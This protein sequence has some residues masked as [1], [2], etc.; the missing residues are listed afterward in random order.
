MI[1]RCIDTTVPLIG[2]TLLSPATSLLTWSAVLLPLRKNPVSLRN[3]TTQGMALTRQDPLLDQLFR[4]RPVLQMPLELCSQ[5]CL[6][7]V[8]LLSREGIIGRALEDI[9]L[10]QLCSV[11]AMGEERVERSGSGA[12]RVQV[13]RC[14]DTG[15]G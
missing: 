5:L 4:L 3:A 2:L 8:G 9:F 14:V 6:H 11:R 7:Q 1:V 10:L 15:R 13:V 12:V